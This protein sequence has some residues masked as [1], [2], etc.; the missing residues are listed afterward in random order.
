MRRLFIL[1][2]L[3]FAGCQ[4]SPI[5]TP[6]PSPTGTPLPQPSDTPTQTQ[7]PTET[8]VPTETPT[9]TITLPPT[10]PPTPTTMPTPVNTPFP[11]VGFTYD[12]SEQ[13]E[14]PANILTV[15][16]NPV[17]AYVNTNNRTST[18]GTPQPGND[19]ETLFYHSPGGGG[20]ITLLELDAG[21]GTQIYLSPTGRSIAYFREGSS[22]AT[23]GLYVL[24]L[25]IGFSGRLLAVPSLAQ[26][27][28]FNQPTWSPLGDQLAIAVPTAYAMDIY[29][30]GSDGTNPRN[31]TDHPAYDI[32]PQWSPDGR[33]ILFVSDRAQCP[34]WTPGEPATCDEPDALPP[35]GGNL[36]VYDT[37]T[38][39]VELLADQLITEPPR[40]LNSTTIAFASGDPLFGDSTRDLYTADVTTG[41]VALLAA[42][43]GVNDP[44]KLGEAW[45]ADGSQVL[46]QAANNNTE[47]V[48]MS[49]AGEPL[50]RTNDLTFARYGMAADWSPDSEFVAVGGVDG[51][52]PYGIT[53]IRVPTS[54]SQSFS[55]TARGNPP[56]SMCD[57]MY[58]PDGRLAFTG[59]R[60]QATNA[61]DG[62]VD[63]YVANSNGLGATNLTADLRGQVALIGWA[64]GSADN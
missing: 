53:V 7:A 33:Y 31:I 10:D 42:S 34:T 35:V 28:F 27:G 63:V 24:D 19:V 57:P 30:V 25:E 17:V 26:R 62:R 49:A 1:F 29:T 39:G 11:E 9:A 13:I 2:A 22:S 14:V 20:R 43:S 46:Y 5:A 59:V 4:L 54:T 48:I 40:W 15:L 47:L 37:T 36:Y 6:T 50:G 16:Q 58:G 3:C 32:W 44:V 60:A 55:F 52:C 23:T 21:T 18:G 51:Q 12:N 64:G 56:P 41:A 8:P 38:E 45:S 61:L